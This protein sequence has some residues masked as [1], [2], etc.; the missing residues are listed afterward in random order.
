MFDVAVLVLRGNLKDG[1]ELKAILEEI[2]PQVCKKLYVKIEVRAGERAETDFYETMKS[3]YHTTAL[4]DPDFDIR[5]LINR[6]RSLTVDRIFEMQTPQETNA[7]QKFDSVVLAGTFDRIHNGHKLL[8][9][10]AVLLTNKLVT[11]G[12][13]SEQ[14]DIIKQ[15]TLSELIAPVS[16]RCATVVELIEDITDGIE[17]RAVPMQDTFGP[18]LYDPDAQCLVLTEETPQGSDEINKKRQQKGFPKLDVHVVPTLDANDDPVSNESKL[19]SSSYRRRELGTL[20]RE[21]AHKLPNTSPYII[22]LIGGIASGKNQVSKLLADHGCH[23]IVCK[24]VAQELYNS[25]SEVRNRIISTY[26]SGVVAAGT[27]ISCSKLEEIDFSKTEELKSLKKIIIAELESRI[28]SELANTN[29]SV[30]VIDSD[31]LFESKVFE[32]AH[33]VWSVFVPDDEAMRRIC[34]QYNI[35]EDEAKARLEMSGSNTDRIV[36]SNMAFSTLFG[37]EDTKC[38]V[39][40]ALKTLYKKYIPSGKCYKQIVNSCK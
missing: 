34:R 14:M 3:V 18:A 25:K 17:C 7:C 36:R 1:T 10:E 30:A 21:P 28:R 31:L 23:V 32:I 37:D 11:C 12:V 6:H 13:N 19:S 40:R 15:K 16:E 4:I 39:E 29:A 33:Q 27:K 24:D 8:L 26:G 9:T 20:L 35:T 22:G 5:V 2:I 38:Q